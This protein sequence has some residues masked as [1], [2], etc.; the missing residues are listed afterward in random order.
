MARKRRGRGEGSIY[1]R[2]NGTW[3]AT[4]SVGYD[5]TGKRKRRTLFG[6]SKQA[7][8]DKLK[9]QASEVTHL[10]GVD[11]QRIKVGAYMDRWL[12]D[13]AM[14][15]VR[16]T[17]YAN[18]EGVIKNHI[19]P[20]IGGLQL[21]KLA[22]LNIHGMYS[23]MQQSGKSAETIRL[24]HAVLRRALKQAVRWRLIPYNM[25]ADVDRPKVE[26]ADITPLTA[27]QVNRLI[28]AA[29]D[30]RLEA[31][32]IMAVTTGMRLG[33]LFG[34]QWCDVDLRG[35]AVMVQ[36][37][38]QELKG[39]LTLAEP[40]TAR[41]RRRI[42]LPQMAV[43]ALI[44]HKAR[45]MTEGLAGC[46]WVFCNAAGGPLRRSHFHFDEFKPLLKRASLPDIRFHDLRHTSATLLLSH[47]IHPK[48]V[49]E[50]LGHSQIS[51]TLDTYSHVLPTMQLEA[52]GKFDQ[53][54]QPK[55]RT[56]RK[57]ALSK[58]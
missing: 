39:I 24:V 50:R 29:R 57:T 26:K 3:C 19:K 51:V 2:A 13:A 32:Y 38:L 34:L 25:S 14:A 9:K 46:E 41:A 30:E 27:D 43:D 4:I 21:A 17:T 53:I 10:Q 35:R 18:Y 54:L 58:G 8:L 28:E 47:G 7:V 11:S 23:S 12:K 16:P 1:Q 42:D 45:M 37:S 31:I 36:H 48:V 52:A 33:E 44:R 15:R 22:A 55:T 6:E 40:K 5:N 56:R 49:Q 20:Y